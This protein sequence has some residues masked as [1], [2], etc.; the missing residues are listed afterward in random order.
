MT[1]LYWVRMDVGFAVLTATS[2]L[3]ITCPCALGLATPTAIVSSAGWGTRHG[4]VIKSAA[5]LERLG[6]T[7]HF[8]FDKTGALTEGKPKVKSVRPLNGVGEDDV[9]RIASTLERY[10]EHPFAKA[11][12]S[13]RNGNDVRVD[14]F[15]ALPGL[16]VTGVIE[17][18]RY[19]VGSAKFLESMNVTMEKPVRD[20]ITRSERDGFS[21]VFCFRDDRVIGYIVVGDTL[22]SD[23]AVTLESLGKD[24][25]KLTLLSGDRRSVAERV[26]LELPGM[27]VLAEM[28]PEGKI[29]AVEE[30][31]GRGDVVAMVGDG[32]NDALALVRADVGIAV[33]SGTDVA[34]ESADVVIL[35][36]KIFKV[37]EA[38]D[39]A[40]RTLRTIRQNIGIS[41]L[42]NIVMVPLAVMGYIT[43]V[44]AAVAMPISSFLV[45]GNAARLQK[46]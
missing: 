12:V 3:I 44:V 25:M 32:I 30:I 23:S 40:V 27:N 24:G 31:M 17:G 22:R 9:L 35:G 19:S 8:V 13:A 20:E 6:K 2:V 37:K 5:A 16:G 18:A 10:S 45:I 42:Y 41:I 1:F 43:P 4:I 15:E 14:K 21:T 46:G 36:E 34:L 39:L 33:G 7:N 28:S 29:G 38:R 26:A 11:I